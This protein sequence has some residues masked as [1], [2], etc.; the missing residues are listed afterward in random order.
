MRI[1][2]VHHNHEMSCLVTE[3]GALEAINHHT[4]HMRHCVGVNGRKRMQI[5]V[6]VVIILEEIME[7]MGLEEHMP[8]WPHQH[9][10]IMKVEV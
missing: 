9:T 6:I 3:E 1:P 7:C 2:A 5:E 10:W 8:A 4:T